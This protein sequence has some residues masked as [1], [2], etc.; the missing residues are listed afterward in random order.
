MDHE[1]CV[2]YILNVS[3]ILIHMPV[4][5]IRLLPQHCYSLSATV[6]NMLITIHL[7]TISN[8]V[9]IM[10]MPTYVAASCH[11]LQ[12]Y[13]TVVTQIVDEIKTRKQL[14]QRKTNIEITVLILIY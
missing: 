8:G 1:L 10:I 2:E 7:K 11:Y 9:L 6:H 13:F 12:I 4:N 14:L 3:D 5:R